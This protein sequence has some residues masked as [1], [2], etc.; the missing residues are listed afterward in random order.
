MIFEPPLKVDVLIVGAGPAGS[1]AAEEI[2]KKDVDVLVIDKKQEIGTPK[3]CGEAVGIKAMEEIGIKID[4]SWIAG[5]IKGARFYPPSGKF[6]EINFGKIMGYILE[7]KIFEKWLASKAIKSGAKY[8]VKTQA[9]GIKKENDKWKVKMKSFG[10]KF[11][12]KAK[13]V[14]GAD[15]IE[16]KIGRWA[17]LNQK[18]GKYSPG[19][20]YE[21]IGVNADHSMLHIFFGNKIAPMGYG[22]IFPK[23]FSSNVGIGILVKESSKKTVKE[24]LDIFIGSHP[25]IFENAY[26]IEMNAGIAPVSHSTKMVADGIML[27]GDAGQVVDLGTGAGIFRA[28]ESAKMASR[29]ALKA[30]EKG[31]FSIKQLKRYEREWEGK[32]KR[33]IVRQ[34]RIRSFLEKMTDRDIDQIADIINGED[35]MKLSEGNYAFFVKKLM[36]NAPSMLPLIKNFFRKS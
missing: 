28:M 36:K 1:V 9:I 33:K 16:S 12:I 22:W 13:L 10:E 23:K 29:T 21:M 32:Y 31:D 5:R 11:E 25:E 35:L 18:M 8:L 17:G 6:I 34:T 26:P 19:F 14:I 7:R 2:A 30:I 27:I 20:Q 15:G 4:E 3:R 24:Y